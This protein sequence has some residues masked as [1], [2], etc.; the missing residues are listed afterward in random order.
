MGALILVSGAAS[1][2][3]K[4]DKCL[5]LLGLLLVISTMVQWWRDVAREATF[6]GKHSTKVEAGLRM[7]MVLF[8]VSEVFFFLAFF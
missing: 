7:G 3:H 5:V 6:Q 2:I 8:I 4:F 1:W